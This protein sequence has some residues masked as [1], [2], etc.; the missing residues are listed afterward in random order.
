MELKNTIIYHNTSESS[1]SNKSI[2]QKPTDKACKDSYKEISNY[3]IPSDPIRYPRIQD[4]NTNQ[5][6]Y[7]YRSNFH[8]LI[9]I[10]MQALVPNIELGLY[11]NH[12]H[13]DIE[14]WINNTKSYIKLLNDNIQHKCNKKLKTLNLIKKQAELSDKLDVNNIKNLPD[15]IINHIYGYLLPETRIK[16][17]L[18]KY[19]EYSKNLQK[20]TSENLKSYLRNIQKVYMNKAFDYDMRFP[21]RQSCILKRP[22]FYL[23]FSKKQDGVQQLQTLLETL[24]NAIPKTEDFNRYFQNYAL[25][26][27]QSMIYISIYKNKEL[28]KN[29]KRTTA[30]EPTQAPTA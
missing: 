6:Q 23:S 9:H 18:G 3:P 10:N 2:K 17:L 28:S 19:P 27:L 16:L 11:N 1:K 14:T 5:Y 26:L 30:P 20:L 4:T 22:D 25:K 12:T 29:K 21:E 7:N 13:Q 8:D 24:R 15:E